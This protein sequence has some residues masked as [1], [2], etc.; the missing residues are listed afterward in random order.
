MSWK[1][2][3]FIRRVGV[4]V[5]HPPPGKIIINLINYIFFFN[6][7]SLT[8]QIEIELSTKV[9][10]LIAKRSRKKIMQLHTNIFRNLSIQSDH[11]A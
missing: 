5:E 7:H 8:K 1:K 4:R 6:F 3:T 10:I 9:Y 2:K 11:C